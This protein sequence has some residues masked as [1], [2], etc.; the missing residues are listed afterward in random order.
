MV[1][2][3]SPSIHFVALQAAERLTADPNVLALV[4]F[5]PQRDAGDGRTP[6]LDTGL[7]PLG[8]EPA[9]VQCWRTTAPVR[10]F[11]EGRL[12]VHS[13][14]G[15]ALIVATAMDQGDPEA[16]AEALYNDLI[17]AAEKLDCPHVLRVWQYLPRITEPLGEED[18][19]RAYCAG[20]RRALTRLDR[21]RDS[22]LPAACLLGDQ[23]D[24]ILLYALV[25]AAPGAQVENPRQVSAFH[26]PAQYGKASPSFSRALVKQWPDGRR[27]LYIS[28]TASVVGH[29]TL[30]ADI[31]EQTRETL[32]N[33]EALVRAGATTG[34]P[35]VSGLAAID[36]IKVYI[37]HRTDYPVVHKELSARLPADHPVLYLHADVC[38]PDLLVEIE[39][40]VSQ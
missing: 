17:S 25:S 29:A 34:G 1:E 35:D 30:H 23:N 12:A 8:S 32:T 37:R 28:G 31:L 39:G 18:R 36:P 20:R 26:Y 19:Y 9:P 38:R 13:A 15:L 5:A 22:T 24:S 3:L 2:P 27:Q 33:L 21:H 4:R 16:A 14:P 40:I 6:W 11:R 10:H 7:S